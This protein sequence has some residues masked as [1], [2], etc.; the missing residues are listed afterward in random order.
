MPA[1]VSTVSVLLAKE[2]SVPS[3]PIYASPTFISANNSPSQRL[4][5]R[6]IFMLSLSTEFRDP[7][8]IPSVVQ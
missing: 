1:G 5:L 3:L 7:L 8:V 2:I 4:E 6:K